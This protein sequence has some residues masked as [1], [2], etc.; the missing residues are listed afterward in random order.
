MSYYAERN[1]LAKYW[2]LLDLDQMISHKTYDRSQTLELL[3]AIMDKLS[4]YDF[5]D[6]TN[7]EIDSITGVDLDG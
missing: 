1:G 6:I 3:S 4:E 5:A 2:E 7:E